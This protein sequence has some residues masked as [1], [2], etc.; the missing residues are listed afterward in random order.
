MVEELVLWGAD[1]NR[2]DNEGTTP[3]MWAVQTAHYGTARVLLAHGADLDLYNASGG[4]AAKGSLNTLEK[5]RA[6]D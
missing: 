2:A 1:L 3:L 5:C 4:T 6:G